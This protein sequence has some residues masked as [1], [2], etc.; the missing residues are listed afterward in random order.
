MGADEPD[1]AADLDKMHI[2]DVS[3]LAADAKPA[4]GYE[5]I[6][7]AEQEFAASGTDE[8]QGEMPAQ[9]AE[10]KGFVAKFVLTPCIAVAG[11]AGRHRF[12]LGA[13]VVIIAGL[14]VTKK[15]RSFS[16]AWRRW[17]SGR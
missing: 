7:P 4:Q 15:K 8:A 1:P 13:A 12:I 3:L 10:S 2:A 17:N 9:E 5:E 14:I 11:F 6:Q 16:G